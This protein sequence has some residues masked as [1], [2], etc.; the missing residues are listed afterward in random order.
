MGLTAMTNPIPVLQGQP[1]FL[2]QLASANIQIL[3]KSES[4]A[5]LTTYP[6]V[7]VGNSPFMYVRITAAVGMELGIAF[8]ADAAGTQSLFGDV[9]FNPATSGDAIACIPI[10]GPYVKFTVDRAAYP[11]TI[12]ID[13]FAVPSRFNV[14]SGTDGENTLISSD[15]T[16]IG[17]GGSLTLNAG[18]VR[19]GRI[20][21]NAELEGAASFI[22]RLYC[23]NFAGGATF[24]GV[25]RESN[26]A[27]S[28]QLYAPALPL[29]V[30]I[31]NQTAAAHNSFCSVVHH[32]FDD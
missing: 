22:A 27:R 6:I 30:L 15:A 11:G 20:T 19:A 29:R 9:M 13:A 5:A 32:P 24:L 14:Y 18:A 17:A 21:F 16:S 1:D 26:A 25:I 10:R 31:Q 7:Y 3:R 23:D 4:I 28:I 12:N 8:F 2:R